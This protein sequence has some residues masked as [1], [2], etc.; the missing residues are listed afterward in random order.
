MMV[1]YAAPPIPMTIQR[2]PKSLTYPIVNI[3]AA[4]IPIEPV[5]K[6]STENLNDNFGNIAIPPI[7]APGPKDP[8]R[9]PKPVESSLS[10][11]LARSGK[12]DNSESTT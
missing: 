4:K 2:T 6:D 8:K 5:S 11:C 10:S 1:M 7:I 12:R 9:N 3:T